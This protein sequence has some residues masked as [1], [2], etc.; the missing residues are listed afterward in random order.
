MTSQAG[1][2]RPGMPAAL[3]PAEGAGTTAWRVPRVESVAGSGSSEPT[4]DAAPAGIAN[5]LAA[6]VREAVGYERAQEG[7]D[8]TQEEPAETDS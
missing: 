5:L 6:M 3:P 8:G 2:K 7:T 4:S 1:P